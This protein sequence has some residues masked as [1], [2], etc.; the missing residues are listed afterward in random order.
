MRDR[1]WWLLIAAVLIVVLAMIAIGAAR[2]GS[3]ESTD[4]NF[5]PRSGRL[6]SDAST[7]IA[8]SIA[9]A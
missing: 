1:V 7:H 3:E 8:P 6:P 9:L 5:P 2:V 4:P